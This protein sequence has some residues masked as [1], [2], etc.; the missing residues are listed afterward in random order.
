M[1][2]DH[3]ETPSVGPV[4]EAQI[5]GNGMHSTVVFVSEPLKPEDPSE[6]AFK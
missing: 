2:W 6:E 3:V 5:A 4:A 1:G